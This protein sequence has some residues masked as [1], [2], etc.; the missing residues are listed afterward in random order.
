MDT[1][2][3][4]KKTAKRSTGSRFEVTPIKSPPVPRRLRH[5]HNSDGSLLFPKQNSKP[6]YKLRKGKVSIIDKKHTVNVNMDRITENTSR[7]LQCK[8]CRKSNYNLTAKVISGLVSIE[9]RD[10]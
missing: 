1:K 10:S 3:E 9:S 6:P 4:N 7:H 5:F 8:L 2:Q